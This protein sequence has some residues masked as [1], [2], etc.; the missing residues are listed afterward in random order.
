MS[1]LAD[2]S[3]SP[4]KKAFV[5]SETAFAADI[6]HGE[7]TF[8]QGYVQLWAEGVETAELGSVL[9]TFLH[10]LNQE[11]GGAFDE[12]RM[13]GVLSRKGRQFR[14]KMEDSPADLLVT[15]LIKHFLYHENAPSAFDDNAA[16][17]PTAGAKEAAALA[18]ATDT[19]AHLAVLSGWAAA[20]WC[21]LLQ[22][23]FLHRPVVCVRGA[24]SAAKVTSLEAATQQRAAAT[25]ARLGPAKLAAQA[26]AVAAAQA[27]NS[28]PIPEAMLR[29][30]AVPSASEIPFFHVRSFRL[31]PALGCLAPVAAGAASVSPHEALRAALRSAAAPVGFT[32]SGALGP[33]ELQLDHVSSD[34]LRL[35]VALDTS[36]LSAKQRLFL[37]LLDEVT[38]RLTESREGPILF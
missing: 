29:A 37:P 9:P 7:D 6:F 38:E 22:S 35:E 18:A 16:T 30:V 5:E 17:Q 11:V 34:F 15:P 12:A 13:A 33:F 24:P 21:K 27:E 19:R 10:V 36:G 26:A 4:L 31:D 28:V 20:D 1:Y 2:S 3:S 25:R 23:Q 32:E 8:R 14:A